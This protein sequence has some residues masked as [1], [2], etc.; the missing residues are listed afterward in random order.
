MRNSTIVNGYKYGH[1]FLCGQQ[2]EK[3]CYLLAI[4]NK[5]AYTILF[6]W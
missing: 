6:V 4:T 3:L 2:S 1:K 5:K